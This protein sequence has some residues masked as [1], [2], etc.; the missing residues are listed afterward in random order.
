LI[1]AIRK[2]F[3]HK[4]KLQIIL[5]AG[6]LFIS[7]GILAYLV[8]QQRD[9][10]LNY[11]WDIRFSPFVFSFIIFSLALLLVV[12]IW[13]SMMNDLAAKISFWQH[14]QYFSIA[15][16]TKRIPGTVWYVASRAQFYK[17]QGIARRQ[18][19]LASGVEMAVSMIASIIVSLI[20][21][22]S[23]IARYNVSYWVLILG[24]L[25]SISI[26]HPKVLNWIMRRIGI[27][28]HVFR[29]RHLLKWIAGYIL[30]WILGG[31]ILF[32]I[33]SA[34]WDLPISSVGFVI[35][36]WSLVGVLSNIILFAPTN[37]GLTEVGLS[38]L[39]SNI[40]PSSVAVL[41]SI[42][43][44]IL[45]LVYEIVWALISLMVKRRFQDTHEF[46]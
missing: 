41:A 7:T 28:E 34:F 32:G 37:L 46:E 27:G 33:A 3:T 22:L 24:L 44:R 6:T 8:Y 31:L 2:R 4:S 21:G 23:I 9:A 36:S 13:A 30:A 39:L 16:L 12:V 14:F 42:A 43:S 40:M 20:F 17:D 15:N 35:G 10:L 26:L 1:D 19:A 18:T 5:T 11:D 38:L 45:I 25:G 29:H